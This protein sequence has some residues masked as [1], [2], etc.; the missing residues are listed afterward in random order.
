MIPES[1][2]ALWVSETQSG[3]WRQYGL[4]LPLHSLP[5]LPPDQP[6]RSEGGRTLKSRVISPKSQRQAGFRLS[7]EGQR[8]LASLPNPFLQG[9]GLEERRGRGPRGLPAQW[10]LVLPA[11]PPAVSFERAVVVAMGTEG[12]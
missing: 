7:R 1:L 4:S 3:R 10:I 12:P 8:L 11:W 2:P 9:L 6:E 5:H